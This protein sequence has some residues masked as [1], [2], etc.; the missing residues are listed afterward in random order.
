MLKILLYRV[1]QTKPVE[2]KAK[3][4]LFTQII[5]LFFSGERLLRIEGWVNLHLFSSFLLIAPDPSL[6]RWTSLSYWKLAL[7]GWGLRPAEGS[8]TGSVQLQG[9][10]SALHLL[11]HL[12]KPTEA[13]GTCKMFESQLVSSLWFPIYFLFPSPGIFLGTCELLKQESKGSG[14]IAW[15]NVSLRLIFSGRCY[16]TNFS[17]FYAILSNMFYINFYMITSP[18]FVVNING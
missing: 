18:N 10:A 4:R 9:R 2:D 11:G 12:R 7:L 13:R 1:G 5:F 14:E 3:S 15:L 8:E 17:C 6:K 16:V